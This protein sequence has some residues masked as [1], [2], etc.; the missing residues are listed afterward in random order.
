VEASGM[1]INKK[2][3]G[4]GIIKLL[5]SMPL[6]LIGLV[7]LAFIYTE[8]N[9]SYWDYRVKGMCELDG[10]VII[11]ESVILTQEE[12]E[13]YGGKNGAIRVP[14]KNSS[15]ASRYPYLKTNLNYIERE[16]NPSVIKR[17]FIVYRVSDN[18]KLG[19][20]ITYSRN[21]GDFPTGIAHPSGFSC[22]DVAGIDLNIE[23]QIFLIKE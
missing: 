15:S 12:Y 9:K 22:R 16:S 19:K 2:Q 20:M 11:Y 23:K 7:I 4:I 14:L 6:L 8:I 10:G 1:N 17:E 3:N 5:V 13:K 18:K 21:G